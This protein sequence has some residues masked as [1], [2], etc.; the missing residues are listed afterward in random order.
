ML[1]II[2]KPVA[3]T[4]FHVGRSGR[5]VGAIVIHIEEG[6]EAGTDS[7]FDDPQSHV[8]AHYSVRKDGEIHQYV[9]EEDE[10]FHAGVIDSPTWLPALHGNPNMFTVGI[11]H[12]GVHTEDITDAQ[13]AAT[14]ELIANV[15][16]R[17]GFTITD[18]TVV[19]HHA[20]RADKLCPG[21]IDVP[22]LIRLANEPTS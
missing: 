13:Y 15:A 14:A 3:A 12:E 4:G 7:W 6:S 9:H 2:Q 1:T 17:W 5:R 20:I 10:A 16:A 22:K 19:P 21:V 11:E 8:S 18:Q